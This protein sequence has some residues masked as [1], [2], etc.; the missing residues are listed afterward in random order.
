M[1]GCIYEC[2]YVCVC[3]LVME[4][5]PSLIYAGVC[6]RLWCT[7]LFKRE[8]RESVSVYIREAGRK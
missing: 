1:S 8:E 6:V 5:C 4:S 7:H 2:F 3:V